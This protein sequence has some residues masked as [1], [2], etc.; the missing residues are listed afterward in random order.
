M[1]FGEWHQGHQYDPGS[2]VRRR[3]YYTSSYCF[4]PRKIDNN[5]LSFRLS[6]DTGHVSTGVTHL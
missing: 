6:N 3:D 5:A 1:C 4:F 2:L